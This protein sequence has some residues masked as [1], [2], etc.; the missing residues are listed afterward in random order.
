MQILLMR[1]RDHFTDLLWYCNLVWQLY[2]QDHKIIQILL[3]GSKLFVS[4]QQ[5]GDPTNQHSLRKYWQ[6]LWACDAQET[7][8]VVTDV[9]SVDAAVTS[10]VSELESIFFIERKAKNNTESFSWWMS[11]LLSQLALARVWFNNWLRCAYGLL[12]LIGQSQSVIDGDRQVVF[13]VTCQVFFCACP[14]P[15][16]FHRSLPRWSYVTNHQK[17]SG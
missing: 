2:S 13:P 16:V 10:V 1:L 12:N 6:E 17:Q 15:N 14:F 3:P 8:M 4:G 9:V 7:T 5:T 11:L